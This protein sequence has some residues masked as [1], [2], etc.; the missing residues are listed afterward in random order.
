M[1]NFPSGGIRCAAAVTCA[2]CTLSPLWPL[3]AQ[4]QALPQRNLLVEWRVG[5]QG[6]RSE[7][8]LGV[9]T[10]GRRGT[11][12]TRRLP[13]PVP[14]GYVVSTQSGHSQTTVIGMGGSVAQTEG[15]SRSVQ[16]IMVFNGGQARLFLGS[17][18]PYTV[19]QWAWGAGQSSS[20]SSSLQSPQG[21]GTSGAGGTGAATSTA[22]STRSSQQGV[23]AWA[24]TAWLDLGQG[25]TVRPRW[26][27]GQAL[28]R[29][30]LEARSRQAG[31]AAGR[32]GAM[33]PDGQVMQTEVATTLAVPLGQWVVVARSGGQGQRSETGTLSTRSLD[34]ADS[35]L[36][37]IR[38]SLP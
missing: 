13:A 3:G 34:E 4:A 33:A 31:N 14:G 23:Q 11:P 5:E 38:V 24:Q 22:T 25:L 8:T 15:E 6:Q 30:E 18:Q 16:Q 10:A 28:V 21:A 35:R 20:Q 7:Q 37:E 19:W 36:L 1:W 32:Y 9:V 17:S 27:G 2:L 29:V 12:E 26:P